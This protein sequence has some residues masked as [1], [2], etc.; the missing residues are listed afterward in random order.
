V[1]EKEARPPVVLFPESPGI[2]WQRMRQRPHELAYQLAAG[3]LE[4]FWVDSNGQR[5]NPHPRLH[6]VRKDDDLYLERPVVFI[7]YPFNYEKLSDIDDPVVVY[8]VLD[9]IQIHETSDTE[10]DLPEGKRAVDYHGRLLKEADLV[11][12]SSRVLY[13]RLADTRQEVLLVP[14]GVA[15]E[16]FDACNLRFLDRPPELTGISAPVIGYHGAVAEW[17]DVEL[18]LEVAAARPAFCFVFVGPVTI[19]DAV[20]PLEEMENVRF[21]GERSPEQVPEYV[22]S[23]DVGTVPFKIDHVTRGVRPLKVLEYLALRKPVVATLLPP[24]ARWPHVQRAA[25]AAEFCSSLD[26][27]VLAARKRELQQDEQLVEFLQ[28]NDWQETAQPLV[29]AVRGQLRGC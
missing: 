5:A 10:F 16:R 12:T 15:L 3:G 9:D 6:V 20:E 8:D 27:A 24:I 2:Q 21:L 17:F 1:Q 19:P 29:Q 7:F 22:A 26:R 4:V 25:N 28:Q 11:T 18:M 23:F 13:E 14:N